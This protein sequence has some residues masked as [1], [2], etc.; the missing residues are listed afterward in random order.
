MIAPVVPA[1]MP[2][3]AFDSSSGKPKFLPAWAAGRRSGS[4]QKAAVWPG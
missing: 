1:A 2:D 3:S 4:C